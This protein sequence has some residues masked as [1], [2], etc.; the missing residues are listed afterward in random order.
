MP[1]LSAIVLAILILFVIK[2]VG[3]IIEYLGLWDV[4]F[5]ATIVVL[6]TLLILILT[7]PPDAFT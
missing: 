4:L 3:F 2:A 5:Y 6:L 1:I 7:A